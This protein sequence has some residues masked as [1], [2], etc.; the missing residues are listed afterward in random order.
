MTL[1]CTGANCWMMPE[2]IYEVEC[3]PWLREIPVPKEDFTVWA[4]CTLVPEPGGT[5]M[6][7]CGCALL[8]WLRRGR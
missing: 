7:M 8:A 3:E 2:T 6:L 5:M 4:D 1:T